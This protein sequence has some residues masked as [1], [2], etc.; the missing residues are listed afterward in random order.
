MAAR[1]LHYTGRPQQGLQFPQCSPRPGYHK[2][3]SC[4]SLVSAETGDH[5]GQDL[6]LFMAL[7]YPSLLAVD[8]AR[9]GEGLE[10][11]R[12]A[13]ASAVHI[14]VC[15]GHFAPGI[16]VGLP[17]IRRLRSAAGMTLDVHLLVERPERFV[18]D[19]IDAGANRVAAH[20]ESTSDFYR[21]AR[22]IRAKGA[23]AGAA[24]NPGTPVEALQDVWGEI[25]FVA[26]LS[27]EPG[28]AEAAFIPKAIEKVRAA[29]KA[30]NRL[31]AR[32][33]VQVEGGINA[34]RARELVEAGA[35]ILVPG[36][37]IFKHAD[38]ER[39]LRELVRQASGTGE[40]IARAGSDRGE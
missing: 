2:T 36:S 35:E 9:L 39:R 15:D 28:E 11:I 13:G 20:L 38:W 6:H 18:A 30:R 22:L 25:D 7:I 19:F 31:Q 14:D 10:V 37:F 24:L 5:R 3:G 1:S 12:R 4:D 16:T 40:N 17:V 34:E 23:Q 33:T 26:I 8:F 21:V 29:C 27:A 32:F